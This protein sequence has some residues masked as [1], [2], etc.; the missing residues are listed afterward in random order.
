MK[1]F[2]TTLVALGLSGTIEAQILSPDPPTTGT[3]TD[4]RAAQLLNRLRQPPPPPAGGF[5]VVEDQ[6]R[7]K[8]PTI[9]RYYTE[10]NRE[11]HADTLIRKRLNIKKIAVVY[12]LNDRL[13]QA[14]AAQQKPTLALFR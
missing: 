8:G 3:L 11:I 1:T 13:R 9:V 6:V 5:W 14:L 4:I 7:Q 10:Q 2:L 12:W